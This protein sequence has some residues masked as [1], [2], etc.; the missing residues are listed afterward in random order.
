[1]SFDDEFDGKNEKIALHKNDEG[2]Q[3]KIDDPFRRCP[4]HIVEKIDLYMGVFP[5][6][7]R[8]AYEN[9]PGEKKAA[10]LFTPGKRIVEDVSPNNLCRDD[11]DDG[12]KYKSGNDIQRAV[13][14]LVHSHPQRSM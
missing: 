14:F 6:G 5:N 8:G 12:E 3:D 10:E 13:L 1:M 7:K 9:Q 11:N 2:V 4:I